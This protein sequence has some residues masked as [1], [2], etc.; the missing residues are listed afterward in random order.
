MAK[1]RNNQ[2]F[3]IVTIISNIFDHFQETRFRQ[4]NR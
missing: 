3:T 2:L 1:I 4:K